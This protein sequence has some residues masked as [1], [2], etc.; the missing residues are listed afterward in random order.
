MERFKE[1]PAHIIEQIKTPYDDPLFPQ[2]AFSLAVQWQ[3]THLKGED[4][5]KNLFFKE[6]DRLSQAIDLT[7]IQ[8]S[9]AVRN[10]RKCI[11]LAELLLAEEG[12]IAKERLD[13]AIAWQQ[14]TLYSLGPSREQD[15]VRNHHIL[16]TLMKLKEDKALRAALYKIT[17][18]YRNTVADQVIRDTLLL[19]ENHTVKSLEARKAALSALLTSLRQNVGSCFAT[20]PA[21]LVQQEQPLQFLQDINDLFSTGRLKRIVG[22]VE[23]AVPFSLTWGACDLGKKY[24]LN[25][26]DPK[27]IYNVAKA[28]GLLFALQK[29]GAFQE[30]TGYK[31]ITLLLENFLKKLLEGKSALLV[32]PTEII[33]K[34]LQEREGITQEDI[35]RHLAR[36]KQGPAGITPHLSIQAVQKKHKEHAIVYYFRNVERAKVFFK[37][38]SSNALLKSWEFTI[39]SFSETKAQFTKWNLYSSLGFEF[40]DEGG[41]GPF[42]YAF[43]KEKLE[44]I[45]L[46]IEEYNSVC[47][48]LYVHV[49]QAK[50]RLEQST[51]DQEARWLRAE[52]QNRLYSYNAQ[53]DLRDEAH[54]KGTRYA[55]LANDLLALYDALFPHYFQEV[56]DA[57]MHEVQE[58][59]YDDSPAG[60]RLLYKHGRSNTSQWTMIYTPEEYIE[61]LSNFFIATE[62]EITSSTVFHGLQK[63]IAEIVTHIVQHIR[64]PYFLE[65]AYERMAKAHKIALIENPTENWKNLEKKPWAYTSGGSMHTLVS[66]YFGLEERVKDV[67][68]WVESPM[69]LFVFI[70][71]ALKNM[72]KEEQQL[73]NG[74][75]KRSLLMHSPTHA[76]LLKAHFEPFHTVWKNKDFTYTWL[77]DNY[78]LPS[79]YFI[80]AF[81][82]SVDHIELLIEEISTTL[83]SM[84]RPFFSSLFVEHM[85]AMSCSSFRR[86][87][88]DKVSREPA[89]KNLAALSSQT[90]DALLYKMLPLCPSYNI[91]KA[92]FTILDNIKTLEKKEK[93]RFKEI[94]KKSTFNTSRTAFV[95]PLYLLEMILSLTA[96]V[97]G[98]A[99]L[100]LNF[101]QEVVACLRAAK[102]MWPEPCLFADTNWERDYFA[103][104][105]NPGNEQLE[106]WR[107]DALGIK[108]EPIVSWDRYLYGVIKEPKWGIFLNPKEYIAATHQRSLRYI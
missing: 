15:G 22:G 53:V 13:K 9:A 72:T 100:P 58:S 7:A 80:E 25:S 18:P 10:R 97:L 12:K 61:A 94:F 11:D 108:G 1:P 3:K 62:A 68:R 43:L 46:L 16:Q 32:T 82:L 38:L 105:V 45:N 76:F 69:D 6:Y 104:V 95:S 66:C 28:P 29:V 34:V 41:I 20:A 96:V 73:L 103:F 47:E 79:V 91:E 56:Y 44:K 77:R 90:I 70:V 2:E 102:Y 64:T 99:S 87:L 4:S 89:F 35:E 85:G 33:E 48:Q 106:L 86:L 98:R 60:F 93:E 57:D 83:P 17:E 78:L 107:I 42:L 59:A 55:H 36:K 8:E 92:L 71:D 40:E 21:I 14:E 65:T 88:L 50:S 75:E 49:K 52:Y 54:H 67:E 101:P 24:L 19:E 23:Y 37:A 81:M 63:D 5:L 84:Y 51:S 39:A 74:K 31:T 26:D 30:E 27:T